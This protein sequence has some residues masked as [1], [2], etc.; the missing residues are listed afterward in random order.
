VIANRLVSASYVSL[1][2][3]LAY[4]GL[5]P[6]Y[7]AAVTSVTTGRPGQWQTPFGRFEFRHI[8]TALLAGYHLLDLA[9][10]QQAFVAAPEKA[11]LDLIYLEPG[12]DSVE[13]LTGLR[14]QNLDRIDVAVLQRQAGQA[15]SPKLRRAAVRVAGLVQ[16]E[17]AEYEAL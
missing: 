13:Y 17:E 12:A 1:Q 11:L 4:Y 16:R 14:L 2:S 5:I 7:V 15:D 10:G 9:G 3:A 8:K 6:D